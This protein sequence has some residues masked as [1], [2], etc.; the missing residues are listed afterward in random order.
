MFGVVMYEPSKECNA[1]GLLRTAHIY[2]AEL[3]CMIGAQY[4][5]RAADTT[6]ASKHIQVLEY[7]SWAE[8]LSDW[9]QS[10][11]LVAVEN[12][13]TAEPLSGYRHYED[14]LY[15]VGNERRGIPEHVLLSCDDTIQISTPRPW[16]LNV[17]TAGSIVISH[18]F[19]SEK[20]LAGP[21]KL[22]E[23]A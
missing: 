9:S 17:A 11:R 16:P 15:I 14:S 5:R 3:F 7:G 23:S 19:L 6:N 2:G 12:T 18:R 21:M 10:M 20:A 22:Q 13:A 8:F 4:S 1:G